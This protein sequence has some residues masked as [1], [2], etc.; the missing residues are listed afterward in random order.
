MSDAGGSERTY[1]I[2][3]LRLEYLLVGA[4][5]VAA[6]VSRFWYIDHKSIWLDEAV[7]WRFAN[8]SLTHMFDLAAHDVHPPFYYGVLHYWVDLFGNSEA[9]LRAPS[10]IAGAA[11]IALLGWAGWRAG[12][13]LLGLSAGL[14][15]LFNPAHLGASQ[16]A[17]M[18]ALVGLLTLASSVALAGFIAKPSV[19]RFVPFAALAV[20]LIYT[21]YSGFIAVAAQGLV[22]G[23][24]GL[25]R[26]VRNRNGWIPVAGVVLVFVL[27]LAYVPWWSTFRAHPRPGGAGGYPPASVELVTNTS[28]SALGLDQA[29]DGW[30]VLVL[31]LA[32]LGLYGVVRRWRDPRVLSVAAIA[33]VPAGQIIV[34]IWVEPVLDARQVAPYT[35]GLAF[36]MGL[37]LVEAMAL[38]RRLPTRVAMRG[39]AAAVAAFGVALLAV[40][41]MQ[42]QNTYVG[43][44]RQDW[45]GVAAEVSRDTGPIYIAPG[46]QW[47]SLAYY[48]G[49]TFGVVPLW[50]ADVARIAA[51]GDAVP[52]QNVSLEGSLIVKGGGNE[53]LIA[54]FR[55]VFAVTELHEY[56]GGI[57]TYSLQPLIET[58]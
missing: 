43:P 28:R 25:D 48:R 22:F 1:R 8:S 18:Y 24:Y 7:S 51:G 35:P 3:H 53:T 46:F 6:L 42:L 11:T 9:A 15:L 19:F 33:L 39:G 29:G 49:T 4:L 14:L 13:W 37:G 55:R 30:L 21:H 23:V 16:E 36:V 58:P 50:Q 20:A 56:E 41:G 57:V 52:P 26:A 40:M 38:A 54:A 47:Q 32:L 17:R 27:V 31:P 44:P 45:R 5:A 34:S 10:A 12:G 2:G